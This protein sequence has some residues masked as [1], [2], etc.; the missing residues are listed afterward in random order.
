M[1]GKVDALAGIGFGPDPA[2]RETAQKLGNQRQ[3]L[4]RYAAPRGHPIWGGYRVAFGEVGQG[5][6]MA[7]RETEVKAET[8]ATQE[9]GLRGDDSQ[10]FQDLRCKKAQET[11]EDYALE[12]DRKQSPKGLLSQDDFRVKTLCLRIRRSD[13]SRSSDP[14][15]DFEFPGFEVVHRSDNRDFAC[16]CKMFERGTIGV[17]SKDGLN[18]IA[19]RDGIDDLLPFGLGFTIPEVGVIAAN[20]LMDC[21]DD[22]IEMFAAGD[23]TGLFFLGG[24]LDGR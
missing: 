22:Q 14:R 13:S 20:T 7:L 10:F 19:P 5:S 23:C 9:I 3:T 15:E 12:M 6:Q 24:E 11:F 1:I 8:F 4:A 18:G 16:V 2:D 17:D 21:L